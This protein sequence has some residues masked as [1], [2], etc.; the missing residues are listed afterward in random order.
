[1]IN[2]WLTA[3]EDLLLD[4]PGNA[5]ESAGPLWV[6]TLARL[7]EVAKETARTNR[8]HWDYFE[9]TDVAP[10]RPFFILTESELAWE[11]YNLRDLAAIGAIDVVYTEPTLETAENHRA[12]KE[13]FVAW[14]SQLI[15]SCAERARSA[16][17]AIAAI[18]QTTFPQRTPRK[19]RDPDKPDTDYFWAS[20]E[21]LIGE[22]DQYRR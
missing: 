14:T 12:A 20:W 11:K 22:T 3:I 1:M 5:D 4:A 16:H 19:Q 10:E 6:P 21:F 15:Q 17:V 9:A 7:G 18:R 2:L 13:Y 8:C